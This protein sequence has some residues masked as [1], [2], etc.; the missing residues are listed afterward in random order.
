ML[1]DPSSARRCAIYTRKST[2]EGLEQAFNSLDAQREACAAFI[3]SQRHEG[4]SA[5]PGSYDDGGFS[6]GSMNRPA[7][8]QLLAD[9]EAGKVDVIVVYKVDRLTRSLAD[10]AKI[11]DVL[12]KRGASFVSVTQAFNTTTSMGRLTL[13]VLLSFAQFEREVT[14]ERIRDKIAA[15]KAKGM[16]MG[17]PVPIGYAVQDRKLVIVDDDA[18]TVRTIFATYLELGSVRDL[19]EELRELSIRTKLHHRRDGSTRGGVAFSRGG[20]HQLLRNRIYRGEMV[21]NGEAYPGEHQAIIDQELWDAV[22]Q[23]LDENAVDRK[24]GRNVREVSL[25]AGLVADEHRRPM[26]ASH[27]NKGSR[28]YRYYVTHPDHARDR[29]A[30]RVPAH[31]LE[32]IVIARVKEHLADISRHLDG[33]SDSCL[34]ARIQAAEESIEHL[35]S[36]DAQRVRA[37]V[38]RLIKRVEVGE[39]RVT[40]ELADGEAGGP[41]LET[42]AAKIRS[43]REVKLVIPG[44]DEEAHARRDGKLIAMLAK[45]QSVRERILAGHSVAEI[46]VDEG[47]S[48]SRIGR[49]ARLGLLASDIVSA[50]VDG[51]QPASTTRTSLWEA[52]SIPLEWEGQRRLLGFA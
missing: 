20:L 10:F 25:L 23:N 48:P 51:R 41:I 18:R 33:S 31:D 34:G 30:W 46:A 27:A 50:V 40:I 12:D 29:Q 47:S 43:G 26:S 24:V 37:A 19:T 15:S 16:W 49:Y 28:R 6:G 52:T 17:G 9:V 11:V 21:H 35:A 13:N 32:Q 5:V 4:W 8:Q 2:E 7:L 3:L 44:S 36:G 38:L 45:A 22:Q 42:P 39:E 14:G 1:N